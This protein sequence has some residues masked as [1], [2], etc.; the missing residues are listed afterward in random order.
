MP[1]FGPSFGTVFHR[2]KKNKHTRILCIVDNIIPHERR[3]IDKPF[4][5][6]FVNSV[7]YFIV[8][9][10]SVQR[11]MSGFTK[12]QPVTLVRHPI[13]DN[14]G[15]L[16]SRSE[17]AKKLNLDPSATYLLFFGFIRDYKGL[18]LLI[19]AMDDVY[20]KENNIKLIIAGEYYKDADQYKK[21]IASLANP[22]S[23]IEHT[24]FIADDDVRY[25]FGVADLVV[26]PYKSAT[27]SGISQLA[28]YFE[29]PMVVT[30]VGG[31]KEIIGDE[32]GGYVVTPDATRI[33]QAIKRY[34]EETDQSAMKSYIRRLKQKYSWTSFFE[35]LERIQQKSD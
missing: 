2:A 18:D 16:I 19:A 4:A 3:L 20:F 11:D 8:M 33:R 29:K 5:Q 17:A 1:F 14:Y 26:Q 7:D 12:N 21:Q 28:I 35:E 30:D 22:D 24:H 13:Y 10:E 6:Y 32:K 23:I 34:M 31:L 25:Y 27:Q 9:S 15:E